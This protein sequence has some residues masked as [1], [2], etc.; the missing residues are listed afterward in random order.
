MTANFSLSFP[1]RV[2][3]LNWGLNSAE[4]G[5]GVGRGVREEGGVSGGRAGYPGGRG[6]GGGVG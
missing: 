4:K 5:E 1:R 6:E 3:S 2:L